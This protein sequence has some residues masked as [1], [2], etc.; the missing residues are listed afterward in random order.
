MSEFLVP[1]DPAGAGEK[2]KSRN[3][4]MKKN[5]PGKPK[6]K[7]PR[8]AKVAVNAGGERAPLPA[9]PASSRS[10]GRGSQ[11]A[12]E[13]KAGGLKKS[14][15]DFLVPALAGL[16]VGAGLVLAWYAW[17][18]GK[19][20]MLNREARAQKEIARLKVDLEN[21]K[22]A[23]QNVR[24]GQKRLFELLNDFYKDGNR[25]PAKPDYFKPARGS[26]AVYWIDGLIWRQYYLYQAQGARGAMQRVN[27]APDKKN[28]VY[29]KKLSPGIWRFA[30][31]AL[32]KEGKETPLSEE[33]VVKMP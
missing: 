9:K 19:Q 8:P 28:F 7:T 12:A 14:G 13:P 26:V 2:K 21:E 4:E 11:P 24:T 17:G 30:V 25:S 18:P 32:N 33:V 29:F 22:M 23:Q 27:E 10:T 15:Q 6:A 16:M 1:P 5:A 3:G 20:K 31:S